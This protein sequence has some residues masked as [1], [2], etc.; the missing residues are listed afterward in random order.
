MISI[1]K[2]AN[3]VPETCGKRVVS[4]VEINNLVPTGMDLDGG[5]LPIRTEKS[6]YCDNI[7]G[8]VIL[9]K[10]WG[11]GPFRIEVERTSSPCKYRNL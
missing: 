10:F 1:L 8:A 11:K 3:A 7:G 4:S 6:A 9:Q 5:G 2:D